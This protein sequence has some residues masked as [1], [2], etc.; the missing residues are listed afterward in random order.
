MER[1]AIITQAISASLSKVAV[2][3][4]R[5]P[6]QTPQ[7]LH[8]RGET[9]LPAAAIAASPEIGGIRPSASFH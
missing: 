2:F 4:K 5:L 9:D 7:R 1:P 8:R 6:I 3:W